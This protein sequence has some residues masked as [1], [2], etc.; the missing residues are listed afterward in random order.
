MGAIVLQTD[1]ASCRVVTRGDSDARVCVTF[2]TSR[3]SVVSCGAGGGIRTLDI[4]LG[5]QQRAAS[6]PL[7]ATPPP[8]SAV[9]WLEEFIASR[10]GER[11]LTVKGEAWIRQTLGNFLSSIPEPLAATRPDIEKFLSGVT[12]AWHRHSHFRAI[13]AFY[14]WL[15]D[16][17]FV[18]VSPCHRMKAPRLP[19]TVLSHPSLSEVSLL[20]AQAPTARDKAIVSLF[21]DTG[22]RVSE[23][24]Q[25]SPDRIAWDKQTIR[26][27][28]KGRKERM[29]K[30]GKQTREFLSQ[31][32]S[33]YEP[34]GNIW[35]LNTNG[36]Q[37]M[38]VRLGK[39]TGIKANPHSFR[40]FFAI[41]L[42]KRGVDSQTIQYLGGW[43][44]LS[45]VERYS[46]AAKQE[47]ALD[48][49]VPLTDS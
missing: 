42:R 2:V 28:G 4:L 21:A 47:I 37:T 7:D 49:Y 43:E 24:A 6:P 20:I 29:T 33:T 39:E 26:I 36:I 16:Q 14:N 18:Q 44:S 48:E 1:A 38:L 46:R 11:G 9:N 32:L 10:R 30:F 40:R 27:S 41:E 23:L 12:G 34:N 25:I 13:R 15:E 19:T 3:D 8:T 17:G 5:K 45:M 31:H 22:M 35:G